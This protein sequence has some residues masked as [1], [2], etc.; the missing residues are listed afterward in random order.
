M[1][2]RTPHRTLVLFAFLAL[3]AC[4]S[5]DDNPTPPPRPVAIASVA[6][7]SSSTDPIVSLGDTRTLTAAALTAA[8]TAVASPALTWTS[9]APAIATVVGNGASATV[10]AVGNGSA[11]ITAT[12]GSV[13]G[14]ATVQVAQRAA[15]VAVTGALPSLA[16]GATVQLAAEARDARDRVVSGASG[17][18]F[19]S[20]DLS[21]AAISPTGVVTGIAPGTSNVTVSATIGGSAVTGT[22]SIAVAFATATGA[23][24]SAQVA[25]TDGNIFTPTP[26]TIV[27]GGSVTWSFG[28][29]PHNVLFQSAGAPADVG[30]VSSTSVSRTFPTAGTYPYTCSLH[31]GMN[32]TVTVQ[33]PGN[34]P[35][36]T[37]LL[38]GTNERPAAV[39]T[40]GTG[41]AAFT[42]NGGTVNYI[43]TFSRL[44][45]APTMAHIHGAGNANQ[46]AG[47]LVDFPTASQTSNTGV[48][49]G[50]FTAANIRGAS[51]Q[52]PISLDSLFTLLRTSN[53]YVNVHTTQFPG[54][55][56]R[57]QT[58]P[59]P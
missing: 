27:A 9:S 30:I 48:L 4:S 1:P 17:F 18:T 46:V 19:A 33:A 8:G 28:T 50:S 7:T 32:G 37:A 43:V 13:Q 47:V 26:V 45:G 57:G 59:R 11:V 15:R 38:N 39:T 10:T 20:S 40:L 3:G 12:A 53:A 2:T 24:S 29:V 35:S 51:G 23:P 44:T 22:T 5:D 21:V 36:F 41:A 56:I 14:T 42:V 54:G 6:V 16:P 31:A 58:V 25:A 49:T 34:A 55:E 52:P